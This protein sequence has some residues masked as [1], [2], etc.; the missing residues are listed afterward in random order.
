MTQMD[1]HQ[2]MKAVSRYPISHKSMD[3]SE[4]KTSYTLAHFVAEFDE[5]VVIVSPRLEPNSFCKSGYS[6]A[7]TIDIGNAS[8]FP[9]DTCLRPDTLDN[10]VSGSDPDPNPAVEHSERGIQPM[11]DGWLEAMLEDRISGWEE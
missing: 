10:H 2:K 1:E 9:V 8:G 7:N 4:V 11:E 6:I 3:S 5:Y